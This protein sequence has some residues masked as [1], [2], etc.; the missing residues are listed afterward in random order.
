AAVM[1][2]DSGKPAQHAIGTPGGKALQQAFTAAHPPAADNV[3]PFFQLFNKPGKVG[4]IMLQVA[5]HGDDEVTARHAK[6]SGKRQRLAGVL[7]KSHSRN[8]A[9]YQG[10][11]PKQAQ[12]VI[13]APIVHKHAFAWARNR[14]HDLLQSSIKRHDALP[15]VVERDGDGVAD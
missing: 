7:A 15:L 3:E 14:V 8:A 2:V 4:W 6:S 1:D 13:A 10:N 5:I 11:F 12:A 9:I